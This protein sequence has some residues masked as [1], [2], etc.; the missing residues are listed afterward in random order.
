MPPWPRKRTSRNRVVP[1]N[2]TAPNSIVPTFV[3]RPRG[4]VKSAPVYGPDT[5]GEDVGGASAG[6]GG[7]ARESLRSL[8]FQNE[9]VWPGFLRVFLPEAV[10]TK[11]SSQALW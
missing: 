4:A 8:P 3:S 10:V 6:A 11:I 2:A 5:G 7:R 1:R 9:A